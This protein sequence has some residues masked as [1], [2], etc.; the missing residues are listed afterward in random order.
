MADVL[1]ITALL[2]SLALNVFLWYRWHSYR[3]KP[4]GSH[5]WTGMMPV[6]K[7]TDKEAE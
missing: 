7:P 6:V 1:L 5:S 2:V 3:A 4:A